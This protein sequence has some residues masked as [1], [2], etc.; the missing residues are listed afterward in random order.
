MEEEMEEAEYKEPK[1][2]QP[3]R[4]KLRAPSTPKD[5]DSWGCNPVDWWL[6]P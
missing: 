1:V 3:N 2:V 5:I 6:C 4:D